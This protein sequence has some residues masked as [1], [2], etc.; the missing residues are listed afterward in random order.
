M[1]GAIATIAILI[2]YAFLSDHIT[3]A[4]KDTEYAQIDTEGVGIGW[5][6]IICCQSHYISNPSCVHHHVHRVH[7]LR[8]L[9]HHRLSPD[10]WR[11]NCKHL[12]L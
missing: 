6:K 3:E 2:G 9:H 5:C 1:I 11:E 12:Y 4:L 10:P 8:L 7:H